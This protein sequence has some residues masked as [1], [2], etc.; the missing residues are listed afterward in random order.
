[1]N[2]YA[3]IEIGATKQQIVLGYMDGSVYQSVCGKVDIAEGAQG[4]LYWIKTTLPP[5][6]DEAV[7]NG[8]VVCGIGVGFGGV[9]ERATGRVL[10]SVQ[11]KGWE[12]IALKEWFE[13]NF[14]LPAIVANDTVCGG[15]CEYL[16]GSGQGTDVFFYTNIGSGIGGSLF[17]NGKDYD[18]QGYGAAYFGQTYIPDPLGSKTPVKIENVCSGLAIEHR[19]RTPGYMPK[20]SLLLDICN[21]KLA[22]LTCRELKTAAEQGDMFAKEEINMVAKS[23][24]IGL[25]NIATLFHPQRM[26]IGGGVSHLGRLLLD[27]MEEAAK[28]MAFSPCS[29]GFDVVLSTHTELCVPIGAILLSAKSEEGV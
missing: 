24:G 13:E 26:S 15:F 22:A 27:P 25:A 7:N 14:K 4:I 28:V 8:H 19:L 12:N 3:G 6:I 10:F 23:V 9:V 18:G 5:L 21:G 1:M 11:V 2:V 29:T 20:D 17:F 16:T